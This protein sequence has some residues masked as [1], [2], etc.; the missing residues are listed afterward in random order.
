MALTYFT[1]GK[2]DI[3]T[4][5]NATGISISFANKNDEMT[6]WDWIFFDIEFSLFI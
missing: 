2:Y 1:I 5:P 6:V 4:K 3:M